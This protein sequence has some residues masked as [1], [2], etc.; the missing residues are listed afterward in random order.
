MATGKPLGP[1][2]DLDSFLK[3]RNRVHR[4]GIELEG[5]WAKVAPG[6]NIVRD[7]S[8]R[9]N[10]DT[11]Y[12]LKLRYVGELASPP[13]EVKTPSNEWSPEF[14]S[15]MRT[16][17]PLT[18]ND[19]CGMH[20]H[21]SFTSCFAYQRLMVPSYPG[22]I[23]AYMSK[24]AAQQGLP[25]THPIWD[26]LANKSRYCQHLFYADD[27][28]RSRGKDYDQH[29]EGHRYTLI[30]YCWSRYQTLECRLL[31]MMGTVDL[32]ISAI[33][34]IVTITNAF[35][36]ATA[37]RTGGALAREERLKLSHVVEEEVTKEEKRT[38]I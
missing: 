8:V 1:P 4:V 28:S 5:G 19:T 22:T 24:W 32:A 9:F 10:E 31:P 2:L 25:L 33:Q 7:G 6:I 27:Q 18:H 3:A 13:L 11:I 26:R 23:V 35:L 12:G 16:N 17:Y 14:L 37:K 38:F 34:E 15:F 21:L 29:R 36:R 30:N 20:V